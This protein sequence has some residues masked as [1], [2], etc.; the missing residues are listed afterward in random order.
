MKN[1]QDERSSFHSASS[2]NTIGN[3][4]QNDRYGQYEHHN[5]YNERYDDQ[6]SQHHD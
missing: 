3:Y 1:N 6:Y 5:H 4:D 2:G